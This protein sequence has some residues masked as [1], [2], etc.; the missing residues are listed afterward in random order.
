MANIRILQDI[1]YGSGNP[2]GTTGTTGGPA[3][4]LT[5]AA[6]GAASGPWNNVAE[7][8]I[9][10]Q[11][12]ALDVS[13][14]QPAKGTGS[15]FGTTGSQA[16]VGQIVA[17]LWTVDTKGVSWSLIATAGQSKL[18]SGTFGVVM[19]P[20]STTT[21]QMEV[22][23][24]GEIVAGVTPSSTTTITPGMFLVA[25]G[26]GWLTCSA[27]TNQNPVYGQTLAIALGTLNPAALTTTAFSPT[28]MNVHI[29]Q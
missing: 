26:N 12:T 23:T 20:A 24:K 18:M 11:V 25:D 13:Q 29:G 1:A 8:E 28:F 14:S 17:Q 27:A 15:S 21:Q 5:S 7:I 3:G 10:T 16:L 6:G 22:I 9:E 19:T 4:G 2:G